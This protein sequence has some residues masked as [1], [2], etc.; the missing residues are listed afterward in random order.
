MHRTRPVTP[1]FPRNLALHG[2]RVALVTESSTVTY[3]ELAARV[4]AA[5]ERLGRRRRLVMLAAANHPDAVVHY[6]A[7]LAAGHP[8]LIV[9][10]DNRQAMQ[11]LGDAYDPD[12]VVAPTGH[13]DPGWEIQERRATPRH[14]L[15][16]DLALLMSTSGSTGSPKLVRLSQQNLQSNAEAIASYLDLRET[17]RAITSLPMA[18]CYGLSV[19]NSHLQR[20]ASLVL[21]DRSV[22]SGEFWDLVR[23]TEATS[24]AGVP[25][26]FD[27]L[28]RVG[29]EDMSLP[30]LRYV[31]QAGGRLDPDRVRR[32]AEL[33]RR[34]GWNLFVMYG[35]T[36]ATA[37][38]SYLPP[39]LASAHPESI[40]VPIPGGWL[41]IDAVDGGES[42]VGELVYRGPNVMLGYAESA[43]D[44]RR[45]RTVNELRTGDLGR[46]GAD[47]LV[48]IV[49]R[50]GGWLKI[51]G[52]RVDPTQIERRL[53][54]EGIA[55]CVVGTDEELVVV[56]EPGA[57]S[58]LATSVREAFGLPTHAVRAFDLPSLP[59]LTNGKLDRV[60]IRAQ[61]AEAPA[62]ATGSPATA[63][64][65]AVLA[66]YADS[67]G[68]AD[69]GLDDTF[70]GL[71]GDSLSYIEVTI[72]LE[73]ALGRLPNG[74][75][76]MPIRELG[77]LAEPP[78]TA[79]A[80]APW[81]RA[82]L[83]MRS[84]ET[85][86]VLRAVAIFLIVGTHIGNFVVP[87]GAHVLMAV[88]GFNFARFRL[89]DAPR[90][91]RFLS[92]LRAVLRIVVPTVLWVAGV[93]LL[94]DQYEL[95]HLFLV[96]ALVHDELWGNLWF[97]ELLVYIL[98]V[99][100]ALLAIPAVDRF[101]RRWPFALA[102]G[103]L[104]AGL[105]I[106][107]DV[108]GAEI[109][110]TM[111]VLWLFAIGWAA[112]RAT[113]T[114]Q[115]ALV[116]AVAIVAVSGY[117]D[118]AGRNLVI[119][120]GL[121]LL[122][123]VPSVRVPSVLVAPMGVLASASLYIYL[124]HWEVFPLLVDLWAFVALGLTLAAGVGVWLVASRLPELVT[125]TWRRLDGGAARPPLIIRRS[126]RT[127]AS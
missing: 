37:R 111:P 53:Q 76:T 64:T 66:L 55:A 9:A 29:F 106:R 110:Y 81:W 63:G 60:A 91:D 52:L 114:W 100:A 3:R 68:R 96:N 86:V 24:F 34:Q 108:I 89:T 11:S 18:Y 62:H 45:G 19:I 27:L 75:E 2:D 16:P 107:F 36:E 116:M 122:T 49:G 94:T 112:S 101:E 97:I 117:F 78:V 44:L 61:V 90:D 10:E 32:Y 92:Q 48:E 98:L 1:W 115:R 54:S 119:L 109:P 25:Y 38:M 123:L 23:R 56:T 113:H 17:D 67:L 82:L 14:R 22:V 21:T 57:P 121:A 58:D 41:E 6:L 126:S 28:D 104:G 42:G 80:T 35:Q 15:H 30:H 71:G 83:R 124:V 47:G 8:L 120:G 125:T 127:S 102:A 26:T 103:V 118:A 69:I 4:E 5:K 95:R 87:G 85:S 72:G 31:T 43:A 70:A 40:G 73:Q 20:G 84:V 77:S 12:V 59:R 105:L 88:A 7:A 33:G 51:A 79:R 99:M 65:E 50:R 39:D 74:W 46:R 13:H 93:M